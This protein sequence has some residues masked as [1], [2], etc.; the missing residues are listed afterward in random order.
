MQA[1]RACGAVVVDIVDGD[2]RHAELV[3][4]P[5]TAGRVAVAVAG[6]A[7]IDIVVIDLGVQEGFDAGFE[8]EFGVV[9]CA[10]TQ[11]GCGT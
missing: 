11:R 2:L 7:L 1:C 6:D 8:A 10:A 9:D 5:L 4:D 3:E